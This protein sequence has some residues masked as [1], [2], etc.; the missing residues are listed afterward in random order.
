VW[1]KGWSEANQR[2]GGNPQVGKYIGI[3][4]AFGVGS[5]ALNVV[6][7]LILWIFCSIEVRHGFSACYCVHEKDAFH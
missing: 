5:A 1:L 4:F 3:Y 6:Q 2:Y 7:T